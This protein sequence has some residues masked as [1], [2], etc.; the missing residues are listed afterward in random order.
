ME[1]IQELKLQK[2]NQSMK[3]CTDPSS[4]DDKNSFE[5]EAF[6]QIFL[7]HWIQKYD[8]NF[9]I[10]WSKTINFRIWWSEHHPNIR[11]QCE[12]SGYYDNVV[13]LYEN[14]NIYRGATYKGKKLIKPEQITSK[15]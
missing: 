11:W 13:I 8:V 12:Y 4:I 2:N 1:I 14:G 5:G 9:L 7:Q 3:D 6:E 10:E 15:S